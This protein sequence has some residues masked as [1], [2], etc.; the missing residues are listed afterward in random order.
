MPR[1]IG[2][3]GRTAV[4]AAVLYL[5]WLLID[6]NV[7]QPELFA[8]IAVALLALGLTTI[9]KRSSTVSLRLHPRMLRYLYRTPL[10][11]IADSFRVCWVL[12]K[13]LMLRR[14]AQGRFRAVRYQAGGDSRPDVTRRAL[15]EWSASI[16]PNRYV[17]GIDRSADTLLVH[18]L[19]ATRGPLDPL[20]LG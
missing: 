1:W 15:T 3:I 8:G 11:L 2:I 19:V 10:L 9:V 7:S 4:R 12:I 16:A 17:I 20:E 18:E 13:T 5:V 6:Y 14:P